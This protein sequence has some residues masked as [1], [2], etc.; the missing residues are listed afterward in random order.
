MWL[1]G[2]V[3]ADVGLAQSRTSGRRAGPFVCSPGGRTP[4]TQ[5]RRPGSCLRTDR[6]NPNHYRH[7][8]RTRRTSS[9]WPNRRSRVAA[10]RISTIQQLGA[11]RASE[12]R[13]R[14][15][16]GASRGHARDSLKRRAPPRPHDI[17]VKRAAGPAAAP[18]GRHRWR[19][20]PWPRARPEFLDDRGTFPAG[21]LLE[22]V[23]TTHVHESLN[24]RRLSASS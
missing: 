15:A 16:P 6:N 24:P 5:K 13:R 8:G 12:Y 1:V 2:V 17:E 11:R 4:P 23:T 9:K 7:P 14:G 18:Q 19:W 10:T 21:A 20:L 3:L 22:Q